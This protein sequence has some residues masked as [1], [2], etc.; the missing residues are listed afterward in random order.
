[1]PTLPFEP[2][3]HGFHFSNR[4][5]NH[6]GPF[7]TYGLCGGMS[8]AAFNYYRH[9]I[10]VPTHQAD[11]F[12]TADG[13]PA[14]DTRL[15]NY[16]YG[17]QLGSFAS[18]SGFL[19]LTWPWQTPEQILQDQYRDSVAQFDRIRRAIDRGQFV[20]LGLRN[21]RIGDLVGHQVL[22]F[23]YE[24]SP[25][26]VWIYDSN[27]PDEPMRVEADPGTERIVH[28]HADGT[29]SGNAASFGSFFVQTELDPANTDVFTGQSRPNYVDLI[30]LGPVLV[31][32]PV[33]DGLH[34]VG[35]RL[36]VSATI[37]NTGDH[38]ARIRELLLYARDP[39]GRNRDNDLGARDTSSTTIAPGQ[40]ITLNRSFERFG[41]EAGVYRFGLAYLS[42]QGHW[43]PI[44]TVDSHGPQIGRESSVELVPG[45]DGGV[46]HG[47]GGY[48]GPGTYFIKA[49]HSGKVLDVNI[50]WFRG[51]DNGRPIGQV[52][53][54][55]GDHQ[56][57]LIE[58]LP[59][60]WVRLK[61]K[62]SGKVMDVERASTSTGAGL[63]QWEWLGGENQQFR[64]EPVADHYRIM[65]RHSRMFLDIAGVSQQ[66]Q[67][68]LTQWT[69]WG[70]NN[71]LFEFI[72]TS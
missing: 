18:A 44:P 22:A 40:R 9:A 59:D 11:D 29:P 43:I 30:S 4:F 48:T 64:I 69:W 66:N 10:P 20:L 26:C 61:A 27:Y 3:R 46:D 58:P 52:D 2:N 16:I 23:G 55:G 12:G 67:A 47:T 31:S 35:E 17:Q 21:S 28:R 13:V 5:T 53:N 45:H 51:Q 65:A 41:D 60:G 7:T 70:G 24:E 25:R 56:K 62:H 15:R 1:M 37:V 6:V 32:P 38:P 68:R 8:L 14:A 54:N 42:E 34:Q 19:W 63:Q 57:F 33:G 49:R 39:A 36:D 72:R 71:Q 50:D